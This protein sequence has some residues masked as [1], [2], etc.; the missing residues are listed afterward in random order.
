MLRPETSKSMTNT[1]HHQAAGPA[2]SDWLDKGMLSID[3]EHV[4]LLLT[5]FHRVG[6]KEGYYLLFELRGTGE[7][8]D[9]ID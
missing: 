2:S 7:A 1:T 9:V 8:K 5:S 6:D 4:L 3:T